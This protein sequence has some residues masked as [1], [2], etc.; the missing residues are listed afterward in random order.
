MQRKKV[1]LEENES[2]SNNNVINSLSWHQ[3][4]LDCV[5]EH[6]THF[7]SWISKKIIKLPFQIIKFML[8]YECLGNELIPNPNSFGYP[9]MSFAPKLEVQMNSQKAIIL[10]GLC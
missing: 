9:K 3:F 5:W 6:D 2:R 7:K 8:I 1:L 4:L 10:F